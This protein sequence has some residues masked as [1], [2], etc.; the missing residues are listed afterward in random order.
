MKIGAIDL[1]YIKDIDKPKS[2]NAE[3]V[4]GAGLSGPIPFEDIA[5]PEKITLTGTLV[6]NAIYTKTLEQQIEDLLALTRLNAAYNSVNVADLKGFLSIIDVKPKVSASKI[7]LREISLDSWLYSDTQYQRYINTNPVIIPND[8]SILFGSG[9]ADSY[10]PLPI[11]VTDY[12][13]GDGFVITRAGKN[14]TITLVK[15]TTNKNIDFDL[16]T[17][18]VNVGECGVW[19]TMDSVNEVDWIKIFNID[20]V[21]VGNC[22]I[23]N[24]FLRINISKT[25][26]TEAIKLYAFVN[27]AWLYV[28]YI[29]FWNC[30]KYKRIRAITP[31]KI[32][33]EIS[34]ATGRGTSIEGKVHKIILP[35]NLGLLLFYT[36]DAYGK[37]WAALPTRFAL[38][39][40]NFIRDYLL[41]ESITSESFTNDNWVLFF[42]LTNNLLRLGCLNKRV[43]LIIKGDGTCYNNTNGYIFSIVMPF[44]VQNLFKECEAMTQGAGVEFY[45]GIDASPKAGNTGSIL[46][47]QAENVYYTF[48]GGTNLPLGT[49]KLFIRAKDSAQIVNDLRI[50]VE[51][52]TD[53]TT[54]LNVTKTLTASFAYYSANVI[55]GSTDNGDTIKL[56]LSKDLVTANTIT[57]DYILW[58]P[59][60]LDSKNGPQDL[61]HQALVEQNLVRD[62][63]LR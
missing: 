43:P 34:E 38:S 30:L 18:E 14:G 1:P 19:D 25:Y 63:V 59:V 36:D 61:A 57:L 31:D 6:K 58:L 21:F 16:G 53:V 47:V 29:D 22:I 48:V 9:G 20:H 52:T 3:L 37:T 23:Q 8:F 51:N 46:N 62:L 13:G 32:E 55:L 54:L 5:E 44:T 26:V 49:Y 12:S 4:W 35:R 27:S 11:G 60:T 56:T 17:D 10:I 2:R 33:V 42:E 50:K 7:G 41:D 39:Y 28:R 24:N 15:A 40:D 45:T